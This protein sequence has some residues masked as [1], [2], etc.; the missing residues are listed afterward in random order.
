MITDDL[1]PYYL[2][3]WSRM[4]RARDGNIC[5]MCQEVKTINRKMHAHHIDDKESFPG[6]AYELSNGICLCSRCHHQIVHS[7]ISN[8]KVFRCIFK[9]Y[10]KHK[11]Q[12]HFNVKYQYKLKQDEE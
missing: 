1:E 6:I 3:K 10:N 2:R 11:K 9:R 5:F 8:H 7:T 4:I 12:L